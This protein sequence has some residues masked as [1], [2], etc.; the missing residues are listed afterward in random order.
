ME[1]EKLII[2]SYYVKDQVVAIA[3][4]AQSKLHIIIRMCGWFDFSLKAVQS[5]KGTSS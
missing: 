4:S 3:F 2:S 5:F 1:E